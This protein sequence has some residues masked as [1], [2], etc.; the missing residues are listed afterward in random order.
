[1]CKI[2]LGESRQNTA[3]MAVILGFAPGGETT[4]KMEAVAPGTGRSVGD[5]VRTLSKQGMNETHQSGSL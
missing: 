4:G 3:L 5:T 2:L 1:M